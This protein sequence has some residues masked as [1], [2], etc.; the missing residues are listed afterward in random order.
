MRRSQLLAVLCMAAPLVCQSMP[1][2]QQLKL[3]TDYQA[4]RVTKL[5][6]VKAGETRT[7]MDMKGPA[8]ISHIWMTTNRGNDFRRIV[9][10]M[11]WDGETDPS[12]EAPLAD[13]F[14]V[15]HNL[16]G[17]DE[18][19][20][21]P[22][23]ALNP[24][25]GYNSYFPMPFAR[26]AKI[27]ITNDQTTD[28][29]GWVYFQADYQ[30]YV[31]MSKEVP[32]FHAQWRREAP[33]LRRARPYTI[34]EATGKGFLAGMTYHLRVDDTADDWCHGG[35]D[36]VFL[37][38]ETRPYVIKGIGGEDY[39]GASWGINP[40]ITP[41]AGCI[42]DIEDKQLSMYRFYL[43]NPVPFERSVRLAF[44]EL[45]NEV[46]S[47][48]YWYQGEPHQRFFRMPPPD[49]R[50]PDSRFEARENDIE[51][52]PDEQLDVAVI[53][54][55]KGD[56]ATEFAPERSL[57]LKQTVK[58]N[59]ERAYKTDHPGKDDD[60]LVCW[61][62]ARMTLGW[63]DFEPLYRPKM[64]GPRG[65]QT[66]TGS[67]AYAL[68]RVN[69]DR[70]R[71]CTLRLG[72]DDA[73]RAWVNGTRVADLGEEAGFKAKELTLPLRKGEN[74]VLLK[75]ANGFN[76]NWSVF[77]V[78]M[79]FPQRKGLR[80]DRFQDLPPGEEYARPPE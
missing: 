16:P 45:A 32:R 2:E 13:F 76:E 66:V 6:P 30:E 63:L 44:G 31:V 28:V 20:V 67:V 12:V 62:R 65:V 79:A 9:L 36:Y 74:D 42:R 24:L 59:Y 46:T 10:R 23:L 58:T 38:A 61:E 11:Y 21:N 57:D 53:G 35:G 41:Y 1:F 29:K 5:F 54:P 70:A 18:R 50:G 49:L 39:F 19:F 48:G 26:Q 34:I 15:G 33:A 4:R 25:N 51:L 75:V 68:L 17:I 64:K 72:H 7:L 14:G 8:C 71:S 43:E 3:P 27:T 40:Y 55:F 56:I 73:V 22:C 77:A 80:F 52:L 78:S 47:V 37:D 60:R 69:S